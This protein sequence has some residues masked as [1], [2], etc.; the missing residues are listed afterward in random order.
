MKLEGIKV[1]DLSQFL[2]GPHLTMMM[3]DH[4]ADVI[5]IEAPSGEPTREIGKKQGGTTVWFNNTHRGKRSVVLDLQ[6]DAGRRLAR[7]LAVKADVVVE[8]FRPG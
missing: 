2:P 8:N 4:G 5:R 6:T 3:A 7:E 1:L